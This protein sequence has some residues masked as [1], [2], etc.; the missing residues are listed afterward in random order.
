VLDELVRDLRIE[1]SVLCRSLMAAPW[2]FGVSAK[3]EGSFHVVLEGSGW[4]EAEGVDAPVPVRRGDVV[5]L[6]RGTGHV[7]RDA[8]STAAPSLS[9]ILAHHD[10]VDGELHFGGDDGPL[11][12]IVCGVFRMDDPVRSPWIEG[13]PVVIHAPSASP[14]DGWRL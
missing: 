10:V 5:V 9:T 1:S 2:G 11:T 13:L 12:E 7:V 6:P 3:D 8:P 14:R 4:L